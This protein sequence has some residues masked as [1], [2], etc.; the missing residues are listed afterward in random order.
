[1]KNEF[2]VKL[3]ALQQDGKE[4]ISSPANWLIQEP[5]LDVNT[6]IDSIIQDLYNSLLLEGNIDKVAR[7]H[8]FIGSPGNG[9]SA[10]MGK[11][12][13]YLVKNRACNIM[14]E[15]DCLIQD[16]Q[17]G[18]IPY[19]IMI[20]ESNNKFPSAKII[21]DASVVKNPFSP[22]ANP[23][24]EL[25]S[26]IEEAWD[27]GISIIICTNR[28]VLEKAYWDNHANNNIN[29]TTW[30]KIIKDIVGSKNALFGELSGTKYFT[31]KKAI[32]N[33]V[34]VSYS[35]LDNRSLLISSDIMK[36]LIEKAIDDKNWE[37]CLSC[38]ERGYCPFKANQEWLSD[39]DFIEKLLK[40]LK[41]AEVF[42]GQAIVFREALAFI[43]LIL[44]GC[45]SDYE[46]SVHPCDWVKMNADSGDFISLACRRI[47]MLLYASQNP[48]GLEHD[49]AL[50]KKQV[51]SL[52]KFI[53]YVRE[54]NMH[55]DKILDNIVN[56]VIDKIVKASNPSI[57]VG[58]TRLLG[59]NGIMS[60]LKPWR[61]PLPLKFL[62]TW[63]GDYNA[64][65]DNV[66]SL[67][68][69]TEKRC[70]DIWQYM[71]QCLEH[72]PGYIALDIHWAVRRWSSNILFSLGFLEEGLTAWSS[73]LDEFIDLLE[74]VELKENKN[75]DD[76][77]KIK[78]LENNLSLMINMFN[79]VRDKNDEIK[80]TD[81]V[82]LTGVW[83]TEKLKPKI[84][85]E[86]KSENLSIVVTFNM[87]DNDSKKEDASISAPL[88]IWLSRYAKKTI[89]PRCIPVELMR[90]IIDAR[91]RA[92][93]KGKYAYED[94]DV[95][96]KINAGEKGYYSLVR[97]SGEVDVKYEPGKL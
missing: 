84:V 41:R 54:A 20:C 90:G 81:F 48:F 17:P 27:R 43:S 6:E 24:Q 88:Y 56:K 97:I 31:S 37:V 62:D 47:Y 75:I 69:D 63:D 25:L 68:T 74:T 40:I 49:K 8:F 73:E 10:A 64:V 93:S 11:L 72:V 58:V 86:D 51:S 23:S 21:Q 53:E 16:L 52:Q 28:G 7:W 79:P 65:K 2:L 29:R 36:K 70:L 83:V 9:K 67:I 95:V 57:D 60:Q 76:L 3:L 94:N 61:E 14:D 33:E 34:K 32:F 89:E 46:K 18:M 19:E 15:H 35:H 78:E 44:S 96:L 59:E 66:S 22:D 12:C 30:F 77:R 85:T 80:L 42:S 91:I 87:S 13:R 38:Q 5:L 45:P 82:S 1:M 26:A 92:A 39:P 50:R 55:N 71:E 4:A